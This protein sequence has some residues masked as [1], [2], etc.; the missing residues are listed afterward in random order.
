MKFS[1][2]DLFLVT[3]IAALAA[4][5]WVDRGRLVAECKGLNDWMDAREDEWLEKLEEHRREISALRSEL[6]LRSAASGN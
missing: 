5:W 4:G 6:K 2:R 3:M 1:L